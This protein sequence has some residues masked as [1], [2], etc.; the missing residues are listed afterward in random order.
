MKRWFIGGVARRFDLNPRT[1]RY[2]EKISILPKVTRSEGRYRV[3]TEATVERPEFILKAKGLGLKLD[4]IKQI[5]LLH[6][7]GKV[8]CDCTRSPIDNRVREIE[9]R[10]ADLTDLKARLQKILTVDV[11]NAQSICPLITDSENIS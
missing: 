10:I 4:E 2:Y 7:Q 5:L 1:I 8:P 11:G 3:Y 6:D 9:R